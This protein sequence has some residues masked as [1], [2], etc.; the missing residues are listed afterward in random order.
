MNVEELYEYCLSIKGAEDCM[1]FGEDTVVMKVCGKVFILFG[2]E[3]EPLMM[4]VK[5][6][7]ENVVILREQYN[8]V[9][10]AYHMNKTHWNSIYMTGEMSDEEIKHWIKHSVEEVVKKLPKKIRQVYY[11]SI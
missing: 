4:M 1:P 8:C 2:L 10:P 7:P 5:C 9:Q 6:S 11:D 3:T